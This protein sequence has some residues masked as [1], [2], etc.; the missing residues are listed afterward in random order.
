[1]YLVKLDKMDTFVDVANLFVPQLLIVEVAKQGSNTD[2]I[3]GSVNDC[4]WSREKHRSDHN[5]GR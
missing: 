5:G 2:L 1:M 3:S 4:S